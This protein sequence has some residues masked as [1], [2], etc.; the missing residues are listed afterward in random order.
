VCVPAGTL[1]FV[2]EDGGG[3]G[4]PPA[5]NL[6]DVSRQTFTPWEPV[7]LVQLSMTLV[8]DT[9]A[10]SP[11]GAAGTAASAAGPETR[12]PPTTVRADAAMARRLTVA[13]F[14]LGTRRL[15]SSVSS[16]GECVDGGLGFTGSG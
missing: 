14:H 11:V 3:F 12:T 2:Y 4:Y 5:Q 13:L 6:V 1:V 15:G 8:P 10:L 7:A 9:V 16:V